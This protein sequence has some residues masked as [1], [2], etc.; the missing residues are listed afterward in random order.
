M[1]LQQN[2]E[3]RIWGSADPDE[4]I[5][6]NLAQT[7]STS[8]AAKDGHWSVTLSPLHAGGPFDLQIAGKSK[9]VLHDVLIGEVWLASGQSNMTFPLRAAVGGDEAIKNS[10]N[11]NIR[12][13]TVPRIDS[14]KGEWRT[15]SPPSAV[16][17]SAVAYFFARD[18]SKSLGVPIGIILSAYPGS[19]IEQ[20]S[21]SDTLQHDAQGLPPSY[22]PPNPNDPNPAAH[23]PPAYLYNMMIE[24]LFPLSMRGVIW[25]QGESNVTRAYQYRAQLE[26]MIRS[27][28]QG[29]RNEDL[30]FLVVQLPGYG[31]HAPQPRDSAWA[32]LREAQALA[33]KDTP[34]TALAVTIDLGA[35]GNLHPPQ[36]LEVGQRVAALAL[37]LTYKRLPVSSGP[38]FG[39]AKIDGN[40]VIVHFAEGTNVLGVQGDG[41][42]TG[43]ALAGSDR[44]FHWANASIEGAA[45]VVTSPE[46][47]KP[48]A[49]R[50]AW[51]DNPVCNLKND[52]GFLA[53]P[54][55]SDDWPGPTAR[56]AQ[57]SRPNSH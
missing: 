50:Y 39:N 28:R 24:P 7:S 27:W 49:I 4:R 42:L 41:P 46:V 19:N 1:V 11:P 37:G 44:K 22:S 5:T 15:C 55:R 8:T 52:A 6:V 31:L 20:W 38:V 48:V 2:Q 40:R 53:A 32:E 36:K 34:A 14:Q 26:A 21:A 25:Y 57:A 45:V 18:L 17:F 10:D 47:S 56:R 13:F 29:F 43:F 35:A 16:S 12:L 3:I 54:F 30:R 51:A 23:F 9:I 33:V